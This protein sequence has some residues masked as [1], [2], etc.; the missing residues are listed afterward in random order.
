MMAAPLVE[1]RQ[2][3]VSPSSDVGPSLAAPGRGLS[4]A[5]TVVDRVPVYRHGLAAAVRRCSSSVAELSILAD[6]R[7]V[8]GDEVVVA[9]IREETDW[10][11]LGGVC[12]SPA[13]PTVVA[14][15][16]TLTAG[17]VERALLI[18]VHGVV[19]ISAE[20]EDIAQVVTAAVGRLT[21]LPSAVAKEVAR[22]RS[23]R[24]DIGLSDGEI[25]W[26]RALAHGLTVSDLA[27]GAG[28]SEREMYRLLARVYAKLGVKRRTEALFHA[29]AVGLLGERT[30]VPRTSG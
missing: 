11:V 28:Y 4:A 16:P 21:I 2:C 24:A 10:D 18:G 7:L 19:E 25:E 13:E 8:G 9:V 3:L 5:I 1:A 14:V 30:P 20:P 27:R 17:M 22:H 6:L 12:T 26:L 29:H 23:S 15:L